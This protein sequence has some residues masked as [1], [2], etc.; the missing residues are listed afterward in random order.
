MIKKI[1]IVCGL[2]NEIWHI[3]FDVAFAKTGGNDGI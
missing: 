3:V 1:Y 2:K